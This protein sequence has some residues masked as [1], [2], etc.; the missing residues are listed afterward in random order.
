MGLSFLKDV[1]R[2]ERTINEMIESITRSGGKVYLSLMDNPDFSV[3][4]DRPVSLNFFVPLTRTE[5]ETT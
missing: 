4:L 2:A 3:K 1:E 5:G